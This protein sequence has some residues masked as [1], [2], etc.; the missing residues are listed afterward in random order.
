ME[1]EFVPIMYVGVSDL[2]H[3]GI[4]TAYLYESFGRVGNNY[5]Y[6][7][8]PRLA[9]ANT[10]QKIRIITGELGTIVTEIYE[11]ISKFEGR[12]VE[13]SNRAI[14]SLILV[15][16]D[17]NLALDFKSIEERARPPKN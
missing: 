2:Y 1:D 14:L 9:L 6:T 17:T 10:N 11:K 12:I 16:Y 7:T 15:A 3:N 5:F 4:F 8:D 13:H